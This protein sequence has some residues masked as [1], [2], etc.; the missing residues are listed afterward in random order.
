MAEAEKTTP[1]EN[2]ASENKEHHEHHR[3]HRGR[4]HRYHGDKK[5][6]RR[7]KGM[8]VAL[9]ALTVVA[10]IGSVAA[11]LLKEPVKRAIRPD[12]STAELQR[13][14]IDGET[15]YELD[16]EWGPVHY[17]QE[18]LIDLSDKS[19][20][21]NF[22]NPEG[23][24]QEV[25][26]QLCVGEDPIIQTGRLQPGDSVTEL[27]LLYR[28]ERQLSA[29]GYTGKL[30]VIAYEL[31]SGEENGKNLEIPVILQVQD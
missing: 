8:I 7:R 10:V 22:I 17:S 5:K 19:I 4:Y 12:Y 24:G 2:P 30:V 21:L 1:Q 29:G 23:S 3:S 13:A 11:L 9:I 15:L 16:S 27:E 25:N 18:I 26:L 14:A 28:V 31:E 6:A 20:R